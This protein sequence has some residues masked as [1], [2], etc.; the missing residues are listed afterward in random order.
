[1]HR[2]LV[3]PAASMSSR[4]GI[5]DVMAIGILLLAWVAMVLL[6]HPAGN[7]PGADS[8]VY[9][10]SVRSLLE[11]GRFSLPS[12]ASAN[13]IVMIYWGALFCLP[14]G[15]SYNALRVATVVLGGAAPIALYGLVCAC[16]GG[17]RRALIAALTLTVNPIFL[18]LA[19]NFM[20]DVPFTALF[21]AALALY[22]DWLQR[23]RRLTFYAAY[24]AALLALFIRQHGAALFVGFAMVH[25]I[26][27]GF[28]RPAIA[29]ALVQVAGV[30]GLQ[31][32]YE[33]WLVS[34]GRV[35]YLGLPA[36]A[37]MFS[38]AAE[39]ALTILVI[40]L[41][42][43]PF[44]GFSLLPFL[45]YAGW[46]KIFIFVPAAGGGYRLSLGRVAAYAL[47][48]FGFF[49]TMQHILPVCDFFS[50]WGPGPLS[51]RDNW[52]TLAHNPPPPGNSDLFWP[53]VSLLS[54][55]ATLMLADPI[56]Q[57]LSLC[58]RNWNKASPS[59]EM[60]TRF[61]LLGVTLTYFAGVLLASN[62]GPVFDRYFMPPLVPLLGLLS[63][64]ATGA[65]TQRSGAWTRPVLVAGALAMFAAY[66]IGGAH[67]YLAWNRTRWRLTDG[68]LAAGVSPHDIDGGVEFNGWYLT[69]DPHYS[70]IPGKRDWWVDR[71]T[72]VISSGPL[73][74]YHEA[75]SESYFS[76]LRFD[77]LKVFVLHKD[78]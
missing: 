32:L 15:F 37:L 77:G 14:F 34:T 53:V 51:L 8:W 46:T 10:L 24:A 13:I 68:L 63:M 7:F 16:G 62:G 27:H 35:H 59:A 12:P 6:I 43:L 64:R 60:L 31:M 50:P 30:I 11:T 67:D 69:S 57:Q 70:A 3:P 22:A 71:D 5:S 56:G 54:I 18:Q 73:A 76:W 39:L 78:K 21:A 20:S 1:M 2:F 19:T 17:R 36:S 41:R 42:F 61:F 74:G 65:A 29:V 45:I 40:C 55:G 33:H 9:G 38:H 49:W 44:I 23:P 25:A 47:L 72:Y 48:G 66:A 26:R 28:R 58:R 4:H 75:Q 52:Y